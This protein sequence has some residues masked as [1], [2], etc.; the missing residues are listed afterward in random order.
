MALVLHIYK[1]KEVLLK[2]I[3]VVEE[4]GLPGAA[5]ADKDIGG[6]V[7]ALGR[8]ELVGVVPE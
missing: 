8:E 1:K 4:R 7:L 5:E 2:V 6:G 3:A